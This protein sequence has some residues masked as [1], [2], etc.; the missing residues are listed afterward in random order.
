ME[1]LENNQPAPKVERISLAELRA[2]AAKLN[3]QENKY[4]QEQREFEEMLKQKKLKKEEKA[5]ME[6]GKSDEEISEE[7]FDMFIQS[8][9]NLS[10]E[11]KQKFMEFLENPLADDTTKK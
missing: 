11:D 7:E 6:Q 2:E 1:E 4:L 9:N 3:E 10:E 8:V 5:R